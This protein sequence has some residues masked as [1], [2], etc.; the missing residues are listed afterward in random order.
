[1][2]EQSRS[3]ETNRR[4]HLGPL[5]P[6]LLFLSLVGLQGCARPSEAQQEEPA[7]LRS[8]EDTRPAVVI[9]PEEAD[10]FWVFAEEKDELGT[11][12]E[13]HVYVDAEDYPDALASFAR[14][15]LGVGGALPMHRHEKT[16]EIAYFLSGEGEVQSDE[17]GEPSI[18]PVRAGH[19]WYTPPGAW[20]AVRNT[21]DV[22]LTLV[23][24]TIPNEERGL[25]S[26][27]RRIG[28]K[29]GSEG[30]PLPPEEFARLAAEHDLVL[31]PPPP[32]EP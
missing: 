2:S 16:E 12:G 29:P 17:S 19:V 18:V 26:F 9:R 14:F 4:C 32:S 7:K 22:P 15:G 8:E 20:H 27:F 13:F 21:G 30:T 28:T 5:S 6:C 10:H 25:I 1:M 23:F 3:L 11:G 31:K 24:A